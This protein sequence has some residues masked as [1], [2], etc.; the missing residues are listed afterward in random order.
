ME[1]LFYC[2]FLQNSTLTFNYSLYRRLQL[3]SFGEEAEEE[4]EILKKTNIKIKSS[5]DVLEDRRLL[6]ANEQENEQVFA[7]FLLGLSFWINLFHCLQLLK[8]IVFLLVVCE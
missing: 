7:F 1:L 4:E 5:H 3:L 6:K 2:S 8:N